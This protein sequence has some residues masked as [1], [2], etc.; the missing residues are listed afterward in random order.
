MI[1]LADELS[2]ESFLDSSFF[3]VLSCRLGGA[4]EKLK[5]EDFTRYTRTSRLTRRCSTHFRIAKSFADFFRD[6]KTG[7]LPK[8]VTTGSL[9]FM[10]QRDMHACM[11]AGY[12]AFFC[13]K[14][15]GDYVG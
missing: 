12:F 11:Q 13:L 7:G 4:F 14:K 2:I 5:V 9:I 10:V 3:S 1:Y 8:N 15:D 6:K